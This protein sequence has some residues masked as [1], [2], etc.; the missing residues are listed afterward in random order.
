MHINSGFCTAHWCV[1]AI[2]SD[3]VV[4]VFLLFCLLYP[5]SDKTG[6][7][8]TSI[9]LFQQWILP[10]FQILKEGH[11]N[12]KNVLLNLTFSNSWKILSNLCDFLNKSELYNCR[13]AGFWTYRLEQ[14]NIV[15]DVWSPQRDLKTLEN[16]ANTVIIVRQS[17]T[18]NLTVHI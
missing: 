8:Y 6:K 12:E 15:N 18:V 10:K 2:L 7:Y 4:W 11:K 17:E 1:L 14:V 9:N 16:S 13:L 3:Q 5:E